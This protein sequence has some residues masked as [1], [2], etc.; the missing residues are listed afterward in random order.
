MGVKLVFVFRDWLWMVFLWAEW[1]IALVRLLVCPGNH[2]A[3][4]LFIIRFFHTASQVA[5]VTQGPEGG[6]NIIAMIAHGI[7]SLIGEKFSRGVFFALRMSSVH[8]PLIIQLLLQKLF[9]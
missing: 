5:K 1:P 7:L 9:S 6:Q 4:G 2:V 3:D 8:L